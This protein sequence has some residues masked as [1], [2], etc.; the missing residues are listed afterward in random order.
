MII[1]PY[2][3]YKNFF[4]YIKGD[5]EID[6]SK[7]KEVE[8][9]DDEGLPKKKYSIEDL[10]R[11]FDSRS[12]NS[13]EITVIKTNFGTFLYY[14]CNDHEKIKNFLKQISKNKS[15]GFFGSH[16]VSDVYTFALAEN[17]EVTRYFYSD[18]GES[19]DEGTPTKFEQENPFT[20]LTNPI[21]NDYKFIDEE[22]VFNYAKW[23]AN[24]DIETQDV[25]ILDMKSYYPTNLNGQLPENIEDKITRNLLISGVDCIGVFFAYNKAEKRVTIAVENIID[26]DRFE[27]YCD[28]ISY[29]NN[30]KEI[31][32]SFKRCLQ[33]LAT[34]KLNE[35]HKTTY[36]IDSFKN[37]IT[38]KN[39]NIAMLTIDTEKK[40]LIGTSRFTKK[41]K[42]V[43]IGKF[44]WPNFNMF[45]ELND[46]TIKKLLK[47][48]LKLIK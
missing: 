10:E 18:E 1:Y 12:Y 22:Y 29:L 19:I 14:N 8:W 30:Y 23:F 37:Q 13:D 21:E 48:I 9:E 35:N 2:F 38:D 6:F 31:E 33:A 7:Y 32:L 25:K 24:F 40:F 34:Y 36:S 42:R 16:R 15:C 43:P 46:F 44:Y 4:Y 5:F 20:Y 17:G 26:N 11:A 27:I 47:R 39:S 41:G 28:E 3:S 45:Y